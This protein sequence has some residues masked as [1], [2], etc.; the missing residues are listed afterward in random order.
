MDFP[1][2]PDLP[3]D[4]AE[5]PIS[6][7]FEDVEFDL[8]DET[9]LADWLAQAAENEGKTLGELAYIF[10]SDEHLL[11]I[12]REHL[13]HDY[14]TDVITFQYSEAHIAGDVFISAERVAENAEVA[15]ATFRHELCRVMVHGLLHLAGHSDKTEADRA[16]MTALENF[17]LAKINL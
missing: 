14:Y 13:Q 2:F 8:P 16:D 7:H 1:A 3:L 17:Y 4:A 15:G 10:C 12:N 6:F 11:G 5:S 9:A